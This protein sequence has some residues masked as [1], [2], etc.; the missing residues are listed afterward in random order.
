MLRDWYME[1][2]PTDDL[3]EY[4]NNVSFEEI[5]K[6]LYRGVD[7]YNV[8]GV[9]DSIIRERVF[10]EMSERFDIDPEVLYTMWLNNAGN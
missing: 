1:T 8:I 2:F 9:G 10:L 3:G 5:Y 7:I 6:Q 4:L